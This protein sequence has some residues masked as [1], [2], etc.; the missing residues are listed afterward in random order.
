MVAGVVT[1][2]VTRINLAAYFCRDGLQTQEL[3]KDTRYPKGF[4][5]YAS[6]PRNCWARTSTMAGV[7]RVRFTRGAYS[8]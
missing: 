6:E 3:C 5:R 4:E 1:Y 8:R 7:T 2:Q